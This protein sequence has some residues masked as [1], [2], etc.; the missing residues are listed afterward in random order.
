MEHIAAY[1]NSMDDMSDE[2]TALSFSFLSI[3]LSVYD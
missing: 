3:C 1:G 2:T